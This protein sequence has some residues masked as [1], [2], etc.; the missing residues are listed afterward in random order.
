M[1]FIHVSLLIE[2]GLL[3]IFYLLLKFEEEKTTLKSI[4]I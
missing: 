4:K 2:L 3:V 1:S